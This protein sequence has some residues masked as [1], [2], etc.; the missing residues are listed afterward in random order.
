MQFPCRSRRS[1][2]QSADIKEI[3][4]N[5]FFLPL[6]HDPNSMVVF[7]PSHCLIGR[8]IASITQPDSTK[9]NEN[10]LS[11]SHVIARMTQIIWKKWKTDYLSHL[12]RRTKWLFEK[13][14]IKDDVW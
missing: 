12:Q 5:P 11:N 7:T 3:L 2:D 6:S 10:R 14:N 4:N 13:E 8:P 1:W 9:V